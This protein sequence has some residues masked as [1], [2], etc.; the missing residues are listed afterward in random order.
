MA[1]LCHNRARECTGCMSCQEE[2]TYHCPSCEHELSADEKVYRQNGEVIGCEYCITEY[3][4]CE[5]LEN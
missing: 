5:Q 3:E 4:A 2:Q 1:M